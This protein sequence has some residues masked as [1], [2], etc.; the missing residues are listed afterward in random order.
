MRCLIT[1]TKAMGYSDIYLDYLCGCGSAGSFYRAGSIDEAAAQLDGRQHDREKIAAILTRQNR[2]YHSSDHTL[3]NIER[4]RENDA[5]CVF[6]GQQAGLFGGPMLVMIKALAVVKAARLYSQQLKRPVIPIFWIAGDDHDFEEANHT[7]VLNRQTEPVR[8]EYASAPPEELPTAEILFDNAQQLDQAKTLLRET[9]GQSDFTDELY[10]LID[11]CYTPRD[12]MVSAFGKFMAAL[13]REHG[14]ALFSPGDADVKRLAAPLFKAIVSR[15]DDLHRI[16]SERNHAISENGYH[17]QVEKK[18][19][20]AHLFYNSNGRKPLLRNGNRFTVGD[21]GLTKE[22]LWARIDSEPEKF[23]PDVITRPI[24]Q[25]YL[26]PVLSQKAGPSEIAYLAQINPVFELFGL[27]TPFHMA[28]ASTTIVENR[29]E[30]LLHDNHIEFGELT[31]D[32]EQVINRVLAQTFPASLEKEFA[33]LRR[34]V[35]FHVKK[36]AAETL[37]F[38]PGLD[39]FARQTHG[40]IDFALKN[41]ESKVFS[42]HKKKSQEVRD[43]I[44]RL[45]RA[46][47]PNRG[48]QERCINISY[49]LSR[50]GFGFIRFLYDS[51][52]SEEKAHQLIDLMEYE[53]QGAPSTP[54]ASSNAN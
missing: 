9:L 36:F 21:Q 13:T 32:I 18:E 41:F 50:Y 20:S 26:F 24:L 31:G 14:L 2:A 27:A 23:S 30:Q 43:R 8:L 15:Q 12:S 40:K 46:L 37:R 52:D 28:R 6:A 10:E 16:L 42:S 35:N 3:A 49:F 34:D 53:T 54:A 22:E 7:F 4:L 19:N 45:H 39:K 38:D 5:L 51:L 29:F 17:I 47:Y 44:Y 25:S 48:L 33:L 1:A 11:R